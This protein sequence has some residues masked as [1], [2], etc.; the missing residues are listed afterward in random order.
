MCDCQLCLLL[1][2]ACVCV[3][4]LLFVICFVGDIEEMSSE[5]ERGREGEGDS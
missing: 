1:M 5:E 2:Y 4:V 3:C